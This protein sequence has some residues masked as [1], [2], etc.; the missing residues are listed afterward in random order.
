MPPNRRDMM[1]AF[2]ATAA[3][4]GCATPGGQPA[5]DWQQFGAADGTAIHYRR[6]L[7]AGSP[8]AV[9]QIVHGAAEHASRYDRFAQRCRRQRLR[10]VRHR[11]SRSR[12]HA[13]ALGPHRRRRPRRLEPHGRRRNRLQ[14]APARRAPRR[15]ARAVRPQPRLVHGA[16]LHRAPRRSAR[17]AGAQRHVVRPAA[18]AGADRPA[19]RRGA[20]GAAG[21]LGGMGG[22]LQGLQQAIRRT[23]RLRVAEPRRRRSEEVRG[24]SAVRLCLHQRAHA[25]HLRR[26]REACATRRSKR[27]SPRRCRCW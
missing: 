4:G 2:A 13:A 8:K 15:Q 3:L 27:A 11:P 16:G 26:L 18:A 17:C 9:I 1:F 7:P 25:R 6:W 5:A 10:G 14:P 21:R 24:R 19:Q 23:H 20:Q 12:P 22:H